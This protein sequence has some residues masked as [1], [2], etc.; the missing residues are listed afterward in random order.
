MDQN[1]YNR[2]K[3]VWDEMMGKNWNQTPQEK[4]AWKSLEE[5]F[6]QGWISRG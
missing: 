6:V 3:K 5:A 1:T 4:S 2:Q